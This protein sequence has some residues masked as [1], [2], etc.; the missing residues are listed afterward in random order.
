MKLT[1]GLQ[2]SEDYMCTLIYLWMKQNAEVLKTYRKVRKFELVDCS[3]V[4]D[5]SRDYSKY[6][7]LVKY[8]GE[9]LAK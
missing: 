6:L 5:S 8:V 7:S 1:S 4:K 3:P 9:Q 2:L